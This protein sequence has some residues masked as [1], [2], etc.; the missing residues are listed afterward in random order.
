M[1][2]INLLVLEVPDLSDESY[3]NQPYTI[4]DNVYNFYFKYNIRAE[5][6]Y[7]SIYQDSDSDETK[8]ISGIPLV[9]GSCL[10]YPNSDLGWQYRIYFSNIYG[11]T[12]QATRDNIGTDYRLYVVEYE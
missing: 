4:G 6:F 7:L 2:I 3:V 1:D 9:N 8:I 12:L 10:V 5:K 11:S